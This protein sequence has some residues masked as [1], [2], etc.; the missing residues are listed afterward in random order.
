MRLYR[1]MYRRRNINY[2]WQAVHHLFL[3]GVTYLNSLWIASRYGWDLVPSFVDAMLDIQA[4]SCCLEAMTSE[5]AP[6]ILL[7]TVHEHTGIRDA[8]ETVSAAMIRPLSAERSASGSGLDAEAGGS[9]DHV[10]VAHDQPGL[11]NFNTDPTLPAMDFSWLLDP[12]RPA[13]PAAATEEHA[14]NILDSFLLH[15]FV[16]LDQ[17]IS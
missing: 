17:P 4:C 1:E 6:V 9:L 13:S 14:D 8:F 5:W 11:S 7:T 15:P 12:S 10:N 16:G 3:S 2:I